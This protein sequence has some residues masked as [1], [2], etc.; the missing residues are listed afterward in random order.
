[1]AL[2]LACLKSNDFEEKPCSQVIDAFNKCVAAAEL[3]RERN[4]QA[5]QLGHFSNT[6]DDPDEIRETV[7][8]R[9]SSNHTCG[10]VPPR[11]T[12]HPNTVRSEQPMS[13]TLP[14]FH[15]SNR[16]ETMLSYHN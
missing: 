6:S 8:R 10:F 4:K 15:P 2:V 1:M 5:R 9:N 3:R 13:L 11:S 16:L 14:W 12:P 7:L